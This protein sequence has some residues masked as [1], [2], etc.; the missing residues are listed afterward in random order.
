MFLVVLWILKALSELLFNDSHVLCF[1]TIVLQKC[2][3]NLKRNVEV[4]FTMLNIVPIV[5]LYK[6]L[7]TKHWM[8]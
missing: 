7:K 5:G 6:K 2:F 8:F 4:C 3:Q 1:S